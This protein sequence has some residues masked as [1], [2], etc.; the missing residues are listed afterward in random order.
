MMTPG[1]NAQRRGI[2]PVLATVI[3]IAITL[4]AAIAISGFVFGLFGTYTNTARVEAISYSCSGTP[5]VC[6]VGLQN[7]G[8]ANTALGGSCTLTFGGAS[9]NGV[10]A[11]SS[12]SLNGGSNAVVTCTGPAGSHASAGSQVEGSI[13][14]NNGA[15]ILFS[16]NGH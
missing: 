9:Y 2:S 10:A 15:D 1:C 5:E 3:L 12:G 14:L 11:I 13:L 4:I 7:I 6:T 16:A 8:T